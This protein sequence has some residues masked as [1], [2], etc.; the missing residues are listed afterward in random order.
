MS[1]LPILV[2]FRL[3]E[4]GQ[5]LVLTAIMLPVLIGAVGMAIDIGYAFDYRQRMQMAADSAA[6][7]GAYAV[8]DSASITASDLATVVNIDTTR[9]GFPNGGSVTITVCR[10]GVD[11]S[12][13]TTY[14]YLPA[15]KAV[16]VTISQPKATFFSG[17]LG[18]SSIT[19]GVSAVASSSSGGGGS[20]A[21][22]IVLDNTC[23]DGAFTSS[24]SSDITVSG[25]V[26]VNSCGSKGLTVSGGGALVAS[27]GI[28]VGCNASGTC[29]NYVASGGSTVSPVP[30]S[31]AQI[32]DPL[33]D[34]PVPTPAGP[35]FS[36]TKITTTA[37][38]DPGIYTGNLEVSGSGVATFNPGIYFING[39]KL[40]I[41]SGGKA[42]GDGVMFYLYNSAQLNIANS[43]T[44]VT[45]SA[46]T[47]GTYRGIWLFQERTN[48]KNPTVSGSAT[49]NV[50]G[51]IYVST[52]GTKLTFS[53]GS[54]SGTLADYTVFV[55][56][57]FTMSG[58]GT[59]NSD[60]SSIGGSPL[61]AK[62]IALAE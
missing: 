50:N 32:E 51:V 44:S 21:N 14:T 42:L 49:V 3:D 47:S 33:K 37:T 16:K 62:G 60:F 20:T 29:G 59:F 34:L 36:G 28:T 8:D 18:L 27:S 54:T 10:P 9:N 41:K 13:P 15:S 12:C 6:L 38:L 40:D 5:V 52:P 7:A 25:S 11:F 43:T 45:M 23:K 53:G 19:V 22:I 61:G 55:V 48:T 58:G 31:G 17:I 24:G 46:P 1:R 57:N 35:T 26:H 2:R 39:G 56:W 4:A 30:I